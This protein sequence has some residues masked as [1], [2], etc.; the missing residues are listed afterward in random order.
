MKQILTINELA[1][2]CGYF[3][4]ANLDSGC[5]NY[6]NNG[7]NCRHSKCKEKEDGIGLCLPSN[8]P[9]A[10]EADEEDCLEMGIE[11]EEGEYMLRNIDE[12]KEIKSENK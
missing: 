2:N 8:C 11:Y 1:N 4:N 12:D 7:Y 6:P 10:H 5:K 9:L 3:F